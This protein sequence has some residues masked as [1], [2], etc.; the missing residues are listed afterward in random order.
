LSGAFAGY[1]VPVDDSAEMLL[2]MSFLAVGVGAA[3]WWVGRR[4]RRIDR[5]PVCR[6]CGFDLYGT[7]HIDYRCSECGARTFPPD[8]IRI[9]NRRAILEMVY[10]GYFLIAAGACGL[11]VAVPSTF[12]V[13]ALAPHKPTFWLRVD[14][15]TDS[16][17]LRGAALKELT[18][19]VSGGRAGAADLLPMIDNLLMIQ[20]DR[21]HWWTTSWGDFIEM[22]HAKGMVSA[23]Q[24]QRYLDHCVFTDLDDSAYSV[25]LRPD[26]RAG[27][28]SP[29][30]ATFAGRGEFG[31]MTLPAHTSVIPFALI[32]RWGVTFDVTQTEN[33]QMQSQQDLS[34]H[35]VGEITVSDGATAQTLAK[36]P[37]DV[38][39]DAMRGKRASRAISVRYATRR[40]AP[41]AVAKQH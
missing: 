38:W 26:I 41:A 10:G 37:V 25:S 28:A 20:A 1:N 15:L 8:G 36:V 22:A 29:F 5:H 3:L 7:I 18:T 21:S 4:G 9:G 39:L 31:A 11:F 33:T 12:N 17:A 30:L 32:G 23:R 35:L 27:R 16:P 24:W 2:L 40:R 34:I 13:E 19:R 14:A 6:Q